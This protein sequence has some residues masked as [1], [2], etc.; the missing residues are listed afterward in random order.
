MRSTEKEIDRIMPEIRR[1]NEALYK[2]YPELRP[3]PAEKLRDAADVIEVREE[4][5]IIYAE[6]NHDLAR[7]FRTREVLLSRA[8]E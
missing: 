2:Q 6:L 5:R 7:L 3:T 1:E 4:T 8:N